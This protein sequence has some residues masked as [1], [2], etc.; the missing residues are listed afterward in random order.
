MDTTPA[1]PAVPARSAPRSP[2]SVWHYLILLALVVAIPLVG[3]A[4]FISERMATSERKAIELTLIS[5]ARS[6]VDSVNRELDKQ[7][8]VAATLAHSRLLLNDDL[9]GFWEQAKQALASARITEKP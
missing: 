1:R 3:L 6:L 4:Y 8:A 9:P 2:L 5:N 7:I